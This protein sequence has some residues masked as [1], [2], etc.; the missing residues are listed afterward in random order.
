MPPYADYKERLEDKAQQ[1][2]E[3]GKPELLLFRD[4]ELLL[5][6]EWRGQHAE[7]N[8][9]ISKTADEFI[10]ASTRIEGQEEEIDKLFAR[11]HHCMN[12]WEWYKF[13]NGN[14]CIGCLDFLCPRCSDSN[15]C[16]RCGFEYV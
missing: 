4:L 12:C 11:R 8:G 16:G 10:E 15:L 7:R 14:M 5:A 13:E 9:G 1:W 3:A 2:V 6:R